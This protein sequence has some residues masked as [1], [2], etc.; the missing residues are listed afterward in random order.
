MPKLGPVS[1]RILVSRLRLF[2]FAG[3]Y[4]EGRHPYMTKGMLALTLTN[5]HEG[6]ISPDLLRRLLRQAGISRERW[7][8]E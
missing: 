4:Y 2:G 3:P 5:H 6:E 8:S 7:F 1:W